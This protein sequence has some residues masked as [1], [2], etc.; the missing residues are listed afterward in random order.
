ME[1]GPSDQRE[2]ETD[3]KKD[4]QRDRVCSARI[5]ISGPCEFHILVLKELVKRAL[6]ALVV[7]FE[8]LWRMGS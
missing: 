8:E 3:K 2:P 5:P 1:G 4:L 7:I 6:N